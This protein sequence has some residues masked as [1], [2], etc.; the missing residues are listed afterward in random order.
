M[1]FITRK[2]GK[3]KEKNNKKTIFLFLKDV[4]LCTGLFNKEK[5]RSLEVKNK[6]KKKRNQ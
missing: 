6:K 5:D 4:M 3:E 2:K 1:F